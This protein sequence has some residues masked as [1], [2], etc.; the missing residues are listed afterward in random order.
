VNEKAVFARDSV[1]AAL[2]ERKVVVL[3]ADWTTADPAITAALARFGR[4]GVPLYVL[5]PP[6][7]EPVILPQILTPEL[8]IDALR[9]LP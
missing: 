2:A 3:V 6:G 1:R 5:Y 4:P 8:F 9:Q 7:G